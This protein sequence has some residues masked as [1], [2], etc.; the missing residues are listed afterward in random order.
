MGLSPSINKVMLTARL[1]RDPEMRG[2]EGSIC[3]MN[4]CAERRVKRGEQWENEPVWIEAAI[5]GTRGLAAMK[6]FK[7]GDAIYLEG[8]LSYSIWEKD[9]KKQSRNSIAVSNWG[10]VGSKGGETGGG[11]GGREEGTSTNW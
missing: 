8:E 7:K 1:G 10:F 6:H 11:G 9:G 3:V 4:V 5:F 2:R